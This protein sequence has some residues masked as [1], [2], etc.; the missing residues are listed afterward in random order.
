MKRFLGILIAFCFLLCGSTVFA[1]ELTF[2]VQDDFLQ[3]VTYKGPDTEC[4]GFETPLEINSGEQGP[5]GPQGPQG[6]P[7]P[8]GPQGSQGIQGLPGLPG[9]AGPTGATGPAGPAG[10]NGLNAFVSTTPEPPGANCADGGIKVESGQDSVVD[11]TTY[12]CNGA[13]GAAGPTGP[14]GPDGPIGPQGPI[15]PIGS[16]GATGATGPAGPAGA[17]GLNA[18]VST[19]P[20][21]PGANCADGGIKVESGQDSVVDTTTYVC[22]GDEGPQGPAGVAGPSG[23]AGAIGPA[24]PAGSTGPAGP[25][26]PAGPPGS[27]GP[28]GPDGPTGPAGTTGAEGITILA[29]GSSGNLSSS[30]TQF[31]DMFLIGSNATETNVSHPMPVAGTI[32]NL[33]VTLN[34]TIGA[35]PRAYTFTVRKNSATPAT[36]I[37][38]QVLG[39]S[40]TA[41]SDSVNCMSVNAGDLID[42]QS[43]PASSPTA[44]QARISAVFHPGAS[45]SP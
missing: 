19:T 38:C 28:A 22:N 9:P 8:P 20:E 27:P 5:V 18:F 4:Q 25:G 3:I 30:S 26:G 45:C 7:G 37:T 43:V 35:A 11:T 34:S 17:N 15:G 16:T 1:E 44:R 21:P 32:T 31:I 41:C 29:G 39:P 13:E 33:S 36:P 40:G 10:V 42:L 2:C 23:P 24:G 14:A 12:V 6:D